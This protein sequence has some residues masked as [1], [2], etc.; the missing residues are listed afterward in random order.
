[1]ATKWIA[2]ILYSQACNCHPQYIAEELVITETILI[3]IYFT[4]D[5]V[6]CILNH[7]PVFLLSIVCNKYYVMAMRQ[8][9]LY[10]FNGHKMEFHAGESHH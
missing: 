3:N 4:I 6:N 2:N 10:H 9:Y 5:C 1:M 8:K 7:H